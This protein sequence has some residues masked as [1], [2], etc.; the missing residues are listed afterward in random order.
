MKKLLVSFFL[1]FAFCTTATSQTTQTLRGKVIDSFSEQALSGVSLKLINETATTQ[2]STDGTFILANLPVG[3]YQ[4]KISSVGY[5][6]QLIQEILVQSG[7]ETILDIRLSPSVNSLKEA[8]VTANSPNLSGAL[9][10]INNITTEQ[11]LRYPATFMDPARLAQSLAGVIN[12]NDQANGLSI[13]GNSPNSMQWRLEGVEIVNPNHLSNAGTFNDQ[14]TQTGGGVN[15]LSAQLLGNMNFLT[16]AFPAEYGNA[17]SGVMDMR[18][19]KGND[20]KREHTVQIGLLGIDLATEGP[21]SKKSKASY[22]INYRYSFTGLLGLMGVS[23]GGEKISF[24]DLSFNFSFPSKKLGDFTVFGV[25]GNSSNIFKGTADQTQWE[26]QKDGQNITFKSVMGVAGV[27]HKKIVGKGIHWRSVLAVSSVENLRQNF[28]L[29]QPTGQENELSI[30]ENKQ[31]TLSFNSSVSKQI[32]EKNS[33]KY[34]LY[35]NTYSISQNEGWI[36]SKMST[37]LFHYVSHEGRWSPRFTTQIGIF[38]SPDRKKTPIEPRLSARYQLSTNN[39]LAFSYGFQVTNN[40]GNHLSGQPAA[41]HFVLNFQKNINENAY[42]KIESFYQSLQ[43][44]AV[45]LQ[46]QSAYSYINDLT[47]N[48]NFSVTNGFSYNGTGQNYGIEATYQR[49]LTKG[50]FVLAN[51][52]V[53]RSVYQNQLNETLPTRFDGRYA[54]NLT[55]GKEWKKTKERTWGINGRITY[56]GGLRDRKIDVLKSEQSNETV[57]TSNEFTE[58]YP[59]Y[60]RTDLRFYFR[61]SKVKYARMLS[62]DIQNATSNEKNVAHEYYDSFQKKVVRNYQL[63]MIPMLN[64]RWEF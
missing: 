26:T 13:R 39:S 47:T 51:A 23:F 1:A 38:A 18:L 59:A 43:G 30:N 44:F 40:F 35:L 7:K 29:L 42:L 24:Q 14:P 55:L 17:L 61:K 16:G 36:S 20:Q 21:F 11:V 54:S 50:F 2:T 8:V 19:R 15:I 49:Y 62:I 5:E 46:S 45:S 60:F 22:L 41:H 27:T 4:L 28:F 37:H 31:S 56:V 48:N 9:T 53:Y 25:G 58:Q 12:T 3:R 57:Y 64:Y 52:T 63:G 6:T 10:S 33:I 32:N 34:G